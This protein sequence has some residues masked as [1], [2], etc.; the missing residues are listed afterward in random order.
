VAPI[1]NC[2]QTNK[3]LGNLTLITHYLSIFFYIDV[4]QKIQWLQSCWSSTKQTSSHRNNLFSPWYIWNIAHL[5][6]N[7]N[8]SLT[9]STLSNTMI[10]HTWFMNRHVAPLWH[11]ILISSQP[12]FA[13][14][15]QYCILSGKATNTNFIVY[16]LT[17][18]FYM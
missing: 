13:L 1:P 14:S 9:H 8:Q 3:A 6:L 11:V 16:G 17:W 15:P 10:D 4:I 7:N 5:A 18:S 2:K 12:V